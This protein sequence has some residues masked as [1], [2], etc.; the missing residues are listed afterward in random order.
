MRIA[1]VITRLIVGGAQENTVSSVL[2]LRQKPD[3]SVTLLSG[4]TQG[5]EG[6]LE[7]KLQAIPG[8]L[9]IV[10]DLIRAVHPWRD[11]Q[12]WR[13]LHLWFRTHRPDL[14]HTHSGKAGIL[15]RL[16]AR[17]AGV[18]V[19][20]HSIHGPSFGPFQGRLAN[21]IFTAAERR[22]A[23]VTDHFIVVADAMRDQYLQAGIGTPE[24]YTRIF[25]GFDLEPFLHSRRDPELAAQ[26]GLRPTDFVVGTIA[27][28][29]Q[30]K[31]HDDFFAAGAELCRRIPHLKLLFVGDGPWRDKFTTLAAQGPLCGRVVFTGL[32]PPTE[33][34]RYVGLMD[35]LAHLSR[36]EGLPRAIPQALA[37]GKPVVAY[38]C[39][40]AREACLEGETGFLLAPGDLNALVNRLGMLADEPQRRAQFGQT[41]QAWVRDRFTLR[42]LVDDQYELYQKLL[43]ASQARQSP[44][45]SR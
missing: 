4:P 28:L 32:V 5:S 35:A 18:P 41:G 30:L 22:A 3:V 37:A 34:C 31:G 44:A 14:V 36:R 12:A 33:V 24:L 13:Q 1:H 17:R 16:A 10:P 38:D 45:A 26:L 43:A 23:R 21:Q 25:S 9:A 19:I 11:L 40:G 15:G 20:V 39:D 6:S 8:L 7:S 42:R 2:G 29:F 27:R